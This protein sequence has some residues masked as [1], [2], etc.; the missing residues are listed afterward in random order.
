MYLETVAL[1]GANIFICGDFELWIDL[2]IS[3]TMEFLGVMNSFNLINK[4][5]TATAIGGHKLDLVLA[6]EDHGLVGDVCVND[7]SL[8]C[9]G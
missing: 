8:R 4:V 1:V 7:M 6:D 5:Q 9:I 2:N 3:S